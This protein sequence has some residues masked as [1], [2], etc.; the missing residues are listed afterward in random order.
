[1]TSMAVVVDASLAIKW[2]LEEPGSQEASKLLDEWKDGEIGLL[3]PEVFATDIAEA[4]HRRCAM[5][6]L[7]IEEATEV[8]EALLENGPML[9]S[10]I[11]GYTHVMQLAS[12]FS[13]PDVNKAHYLALAERESCQCWTADTRLWKAVDSELPWLRWLGEGRN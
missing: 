9:V 11:A 5:G 10:D 13:L 6:E 7:S 12:E 4:L 8:L 3:A 1:M 2:V